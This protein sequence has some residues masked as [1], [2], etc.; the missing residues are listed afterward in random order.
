MSMMNSKKIRIAYY[1]GTGGTKMAV[2]YIYCQLSGES[3]LR[4]HQGS[5]YYA[6]KL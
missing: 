4:G 3:R 2:D 5:D 6:Y 1:T